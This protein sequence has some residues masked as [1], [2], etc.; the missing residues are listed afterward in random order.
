MRIQ[1]FI[2][3]I[4]LLGIVVVSLS[5]FADDWPMWRHD[6]KRTSATDEKLT[7]PL[8][9]AWTFRSLQAD[10]APAPVDPRWVK[11]P[12]V[13]WYTLPISAAGDSLFFTSA[14]DGRI[15]CLDAA[16]GKTRW[17]FMAGAAVNRTPTFWNG[18]VY[19]GSDDGHVYCLNAK[20]GTVVWDFKAAP[21][22]RWFIAYGKPVSVWPVRTDVFVDADPSVNDGKAVAYFGAGIFPYE[23]AFLYAVDAETGKLIWRNGTQCETGWRASMSPAGYLWIKKA[24][25]SLVVARDT[26]GYGGAQ[27]AMVTTYSRVTGAV[28]AWNRDPIPFNGA[29]K[30]GKF[31]GG[32][33]GKGRMMDLDSVFSVRWKRPVFF[34]WDPDI[35]N[36]VYAG[37]VEYYAAFYYDAT[38]GTTLGAR[39]A[40]GKEVL[41]S[42]D[43]KGQANQIIVANGRLFATT[44]EGVIYCFA[45]KGAKTFGTVEEK[46]TPKPFGQNKELGTVADAILKESGVRAGYAVV[47]DSDRGALALELAQRSKLYVAAVFHDAVK[48]AAARQAYEEAGLHVSRLIAYTQKDGEKLPFSRHLADLIV[49]ESAVT[50]GALPADLEE[51]NRVLKPYRGVAFIGGKQAKAALDAWA[52]KTGL[53]GWT[54]VENGGTWA[55][56]VRPGLEDAGGWTHGLGDAGNSSSSNDGALKGPLGTLWYGEPQLGYPGPGALIIDGVFLLHQGGALIARDAYTG[57]E[58]WRRDRSNTDTVCGFG[59]VFLRYLE[60]VVRLDPSTGKELDAYK[61]PFPDSQWQKIAASRDGKT[62]FLVAAGKDVHCTMGVDVATGNI[63]W[64]RNKNEGWGGWGVI[65]DGYI[66]SLGGGAK[67]KLREACIAEMRE[68]LRKTDPKRLAQYEKQLDQRDI[69]VLATIDAKTGKLLYEHGVDIT[70]CGG[71]FLP[72]VGYGGGKNARHYNPRVGFHMMAAKDVVVFATQSGAD[73]G[74]PVWPRGAYKQRGIAVYSG[75]TGKL[76]WHKPCN[77][78]TMPVIADDTI[79]A[80]PW[81][82]D[83]HTGERKQRVHPITGQKADWA[84]CRWDKQCGRFNA[85][86][87]FIFGRSLGVGIVD[88]LNDTGLY[89]FWH[90]RMNCYYDAFSGS[91]MMIKPPN[92]I[93]CRCTWSLPF[94]VA[95]GQVES[96]PPAATGFAQPGPSLPVKHLYLDFGGTGDRRDDEG[97]LWINAPR[98]AGHYLILGY[99]TGT[100]MYEGGGAVQRSS[101][102]TPIENTDTPFVFATATRGLKSCTLPLAEPKSPA[103]SFRVR[104]GF[105]ALPGDKPGQRVFDVLLNGKTV[106]KDLDIIAEAGK[107]DSAIWKEFKIDSARA[108][109]LE[110]KAKA[111]APKSEAMPLISAMVVVR[112]DCIPPTLSGPAQFLEKA[113]V[114]MACDDP[115]GTIHYTLDGSEP[116]KKSAVYKKPLEFSRTSRVRAMFAHNSGRTSIVVE[117]VFTKV[118]PRKVG[119]K[120]LSLGVAYEYYEGSWSKLPSFDELKP[121]AKGVCRVV[122]LEPSRRGSNYALRFTGYIEI[123]KAGSYTFTLGSDDGSRLVIDGETVLDIDGVH[124][125]VTQNKAVE[126]KPGMHKVN[127]LY[128]QGV[129]GAGLLLLHDGPGVNPGPLSLWCEQ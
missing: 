104:L 71:R 126:L 2:R 66:Y 106:I 82:Y 56:R 81:G 45:P 29:R 34:R 14:A 128:F 94:T 127:V 88:T 91:G 43:V 102:F 122:S 98:G 103:G 69:R 72:G 113:R 92:A 41:W 120:M 73:K 114:E 46:A 26:S 123:K 7:P 63:L 97:N 89:T 13:T 129:G 6:A 68:Y 40:G 65:G 124:G 105:S 121:V 18:K 77:Y 39:N 112:T 101:M 57:R 115:D 70:N 1:R 25:N 119:G 60:V 80:E 42:A 20:D 8:E 125:V 4:V 35:S 21:G 62:V 33:A 117:A 31:Y 30:D 58:M 85:S 87:N 90:S 37:G 86:K 116:S 76:L 52:G 36:V 99:Y 10:R 19:A 47:L 118:K 53:D 59:S 95:M 48:A 100:A 22:N 51:L 75:K 24:W 12:W 109:T 16:T 28:G 5:A 23:G 17:Q 49:S 107:A 27:W 78:R 55:K 38:K 9:L 110:L 111:D 54:V 61:P 96:Q 44:R 50:G 64:Q 3:P 74:W 15:V 67:G 83:L 84:F 79:F 93:G 32:V 108:L 11:F